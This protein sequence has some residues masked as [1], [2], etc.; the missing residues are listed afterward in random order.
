M[1]TK[2][3]Q[4]SQMQRNVMGEILT[5]EKGT[6]VCAHVIYKETLVCYKC[7]M[8]VPNI[9]MIFTNT[10]DS[11]KKFTRFPGQFPIKEGKRPQWQPCWD[12]SHS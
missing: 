6:L 4:K 9:D 5:R 2:W 1:A 11:D 7:T 10:P 8:F 3:S 12:P